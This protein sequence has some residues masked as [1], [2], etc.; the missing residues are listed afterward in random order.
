MS[1]TVVPI[2]NL[3]LGPKTRIPFGNG[4]VL[5]DVPDWLKTDKGIVD[6]L[7]YTERCW[8][9]DAKHAWVAEYNAESIGHPDPDWNGDE[10]KSISRD[11]VR[12][13]YPRQSCYVVH[14]TD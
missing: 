2:H 12:V 3:E 1:F 11:Q 14:G 13:R 4:F 10:P 6:N 7:Q 9:R 5:Q 8:N